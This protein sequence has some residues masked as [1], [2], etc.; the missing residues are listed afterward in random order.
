MELVQASLSVAG[1]VSDTEHADRVDGNALDM[2]AGAW[3]FQRARKNREGEWEFAL[4][5]KVVRGAWT[6]ENG[7]VTLFS[8]MIHREAIT[9]AEVS[10]PCGTNEITLAGELPGAMETPEGEPALVTVD[11]AHAQHETAA[12]ISEAGWDYLMRIRETSR[13]CKGKCSVKSCRYLG[14]ARAT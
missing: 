13:P 8:A 11:A 10:V 14:A 12:E 4:D 9:I 5:G 3:L 1:H 2:T 6:D 7:Q